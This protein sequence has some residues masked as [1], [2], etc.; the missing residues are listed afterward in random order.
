LK[1]N[2]PFD[3]IFIDHVKG[4]Y[5]QDYKL[6]LGYGIVPKGGVVIGDNIIC[7]GAPDYL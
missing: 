1:K 2:G 5:L 4:L 7:P 3:A 6:M